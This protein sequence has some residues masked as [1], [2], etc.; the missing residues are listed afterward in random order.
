MVSASKLG[1]SASYAYGKAER[2]K[3]PVGGAAGAGAPAWLAELPSA[4]SFSES[5]AAPA[6]APICN[7]ADLRVSE[8]MG[9]PPG[10]FSRKCKRVERL[11]GRNIQGGAVQEFWEGIQ[12]RYSDNMR[13]PTLAEIHDALAIVY[14]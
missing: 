10:D 8:D 9:I 2:V 1:S 11:T 13:L 5:R 3:G 14:R 6:S 4:A 12:D 7:I